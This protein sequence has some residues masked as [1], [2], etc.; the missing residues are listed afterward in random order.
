MDADF[1]KHPYPSAVQKPS[2][3]FTGVDQVPNNAAALL[4]IGFNN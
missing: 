4:L 2:K 3:W 1:E